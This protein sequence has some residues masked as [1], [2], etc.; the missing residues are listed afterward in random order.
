[1]TVLVGYASEHG[2]TEGV[3]RRIAVRLRE[4]GCTADAQPLAEA[5][6]AEVY[7]A[8]V[9]G[10]AVHGGAWLTEAS[11]YL[12]ANTDA[13]GRMPV[14][15]FSVGLARAVGGWF[16]KHARDPEE[17]ME[18]CRGFDLRE[19][20]LLAGALRPEHIPLPG[21][22]FYRLIGGHYGDFRDWDEI[23]AWA[24]TIAADLS[25]AGASGT[26]SV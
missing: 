2:S 13:L 5:P 15:L 12:R 16:E 26:A 1:M 22:V 18:L 6:G 10:S 23:D 24:D 4:R 7:E 3:A 20:R 25:A 11:D 14:W 9:L 17:I 21:R 19:H 8:A